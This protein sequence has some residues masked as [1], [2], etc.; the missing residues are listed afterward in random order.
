V[1]LLRAAW[2]TFDATASKAKGVTLSVG[3]RGGGRQVLKM[4]EHVREAEAAYLHQLGS[5]PPGSRASMEALR[6][7][8]VEALSARATEQP[9]PNPNKVRR[10]WLPRYAVRRSAWHAL[11]HAWEI[12]DRSS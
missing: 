3:P 10:P 1:S 5:R 4:I 2:A 8:F 12:E 7:A 6:G 9:V 11:D